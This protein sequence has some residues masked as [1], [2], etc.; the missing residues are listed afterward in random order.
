MRDFDRRYPNLFQILSAFAAHDDLNDDA[1]VK[2]HFA[3]SPAVRAT[4]AGAVKELASLKPRP[5]AAKALAT[6]ANRHFD[7]GAQA[8]RWADKILLQIGAKLG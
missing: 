1:I 4:L 7:R 3:K 2:K 8:L 5:G 6:A